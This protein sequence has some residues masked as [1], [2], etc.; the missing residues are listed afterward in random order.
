MPALKIICLLSALIAMPGYAQWTLNNDASS[1]HFISIKA[2]DIAEIHQFN[3]LTGM[4]EDDGSVTVEVEL[5][6]VD[7]LIPIRDERMRDLLFETS[8]FP[9]ATTTT[10]ID[11]Q[12][13]ASLAVG[14]RTTVT[15]EVLLE[16]HGEAAPTIIELQ[17]ARLTENSVLVS[18]RKP[19]VINVGMFNLVDGVEAL[20]SVAG[21]PSISKAVPVTFTLIFE[22]EDS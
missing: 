9:V 19:V 17:A 5:A 20:R 8:I 13:I 16:L 22:R 1:L 2:S 10:R 14:E 21:L 15:S 4:I 11:P 18:T 3:T 12:L 6:S 7:T